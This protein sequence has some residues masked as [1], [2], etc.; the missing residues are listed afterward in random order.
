MNLILRNAPIIHAVATAFLTIQE[1]SWPHPQASRR[2]SLGALAGQQG[3]PLVREFLD[4]MQEVCDA[5]PRVRFFWKDQDLAFLGMSEAL[6]REAGLSSVE[7]CVGLTDTSDPLP[8]RRQ[9]AKY[10]RDDR[11]VMQAGNP[12][13]D[14]LERQDHGEEATRWLRTSKT[15]IRSDGRVIGIL[16]AFDVI[17]AEEAK[18]ISS[19]L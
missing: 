11:R 15:P 1:R 13:F 8:W 7:E 9:A 16:G 2:L 4:V 6:A 19:R 18:L 10:Q 5:F 12:E 3:E 14:I 17:S